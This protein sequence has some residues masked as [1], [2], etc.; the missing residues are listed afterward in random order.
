MVELPAWE[1][2]PVLRIY[3]SELCPDCI[4]CKQDLDAN[5]IEYE[6]I[7]INLSLRDLKGFLKLRDTLP[8]FDHVKELGQIG[9]PT[10]IDEDGTVFLDWAGCLEGKNIPVSHAEGVQGAACSLDGKGC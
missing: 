3:G 1:V 9:I 8:V 2:K 10:L 4:R 5:N 7:D 6:Y